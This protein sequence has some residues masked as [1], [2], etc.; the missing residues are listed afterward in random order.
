MIA[1]SLARL[2]EITG[3]HLAGIDATAAEHLLIDGPVVTDSREAGP[4]SLYVARIGAAADGHDFIA[5]AA[6]R[7]AVAALVT[8]DTGDLPRI[9]VA[10]EQAA[11]VAIAR[12]LID[13]RPDLEVVGITGSSGK[14][15]TK[16]LLGQ[17][18]AA[19]AETIAPVGSFNSEVG[20]PLTVC[21][22]T[23]ATRYLVIEMEL[24][25]SG[26]SNTSPRSP[27]R[28]SGSC[29]ISARPMSAS[30]AHGP[31]SLPPNPNSCR[32]CRPMGWPCSMPTTR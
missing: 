8:A 1:R 12:E 11:F 5:G 7:G 23:D 21:R 29:S 9:V 25:A 14:T 16:D 3:G 22:I 31:R 26:M 13:S 17:V 30:S 28:G 15:S 24:G 2:A 6:Q 18:L 27:R 4:G 10:D 32:P 20:V 19:E